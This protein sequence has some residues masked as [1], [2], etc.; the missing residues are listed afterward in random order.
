MTNALPYF[1]FEI[2]SIGLPGGIERL[3]CFYFTPCCYAAEAE[4]REQW[5]IMLSLF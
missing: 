4:K 1:F 2:R 5:Q 3:D